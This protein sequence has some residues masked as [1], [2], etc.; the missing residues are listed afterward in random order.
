MTVSV[1]ARTPTQRHPR[2]EPLRRA[3][4]S[5]MSRGRAEIKQMGQRSLFRAWHR[6]DIS[7][8][9]RFSRPSPAPC[10]AWEG[11]KGHGIL[12]P[13]QTNTNRCSSCPR[14]RAPGSEVG[15]KVDVG[16][17]FHHRKLPKKSN[18]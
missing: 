8:R 16:P 6:L 12:K 3:R 13:H 17:D 9:Q 10:C 4:W 7:V 15:E 14:C 18:V 1:D 2:L 11:K 5:R